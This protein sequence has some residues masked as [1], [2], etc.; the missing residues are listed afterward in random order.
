M[1]VGYIMEAYS[2]CYSYI[3]RYYSY[4][5]IIHYYYCYSDMLERNLFKL[6]NTD[7]DMKLRYVEDNNNHVQDNDS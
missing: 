7:K 2:M 3:H 4:D 1:V 5:I 6:D